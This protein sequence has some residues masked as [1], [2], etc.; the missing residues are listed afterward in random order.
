MAKIKRGDKDRL[1]AA[2]LVTQ[3]ME[4]G[5]TEKRRQIIRQNLDELVLGVSPFLRLLLQKTDDKKLHTQ[6]HLNGMLFTSEIARE[7]AT[8]M[9]FEEATKLAREDLYWALNY[10]SS[11]LPFEDEKRVDFVIEL[12]LIHGAEYERLGLSEVSWQA[13]C[14]IDPVFEAV[15]IAAQE[16]GSDSLDENA[17]SLILGAEVILEQ[18][19]LRSKLNRISRIVGQLTIAQNE[20]DRLRKQAR[21]WCLAHWTQLPAANRSDGLK[22]QSALPFK[23][24]KVARH[25][26]STLRCPECLENGNTEVSLINELISND[27]GGLYLNFLIRCKNCSL[28]TIV[29]NRCPSSMLLGFSPGDSKRFLINKLLNVQ[30]YFNYL[31]SYSLIPLAADEKISAQCKSIFSSIQEAIPDLIDPEQIKNTNIDIAVIAGMFGPK[32]SPF[33]H[34]CSDGFAIV[35]PEFF[36][37][38]LFRFARLLLLSWGIQNGKQRLRGPAISTEYAKEL[39]K[40]L[41]SE[42]GGFE[43]KTIPLKVP[44]DMT[45]ADLAILE[46]CLTFVIGHEVA[47]ICHKHLDHSASLGV[48]PL[49][50][51][52]YDS[53]QDEIAADKTA[54]RLARVVAERNYTN[55]LVQTFAMASIDIFFTVLTLVESKFPPD[56]Q[57]HPLAHVRRA[58]L[59]SYAG[60]GITSQ[61][62]LF[63]IGAQQ[64]LEA[65]AE[66]QPHKPDLPTTLCGDW[67]KLE[68]AL[69]SLSRGEEKECLKRLIPYLICQPTNDEGWQLLPHILFSESENKGVVSPRSAI[70]VSPELTDGTL[71]INLVQRL[72]KREME[73]NLWVGYVKDLAY[74]AEKK[75]GFQALSLDDELRA[76]RNVLLR[77]KHKPEPDRGTSPALI[78]LDILEKGL[79]REFTY[80]ARFTSFDRPGFAQ[81]RELLLNDPSPVKELLMSLVV[82]RSQDDSEAT[83]LTE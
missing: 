21:E 12:V 32:I 75:G 4:L 31:R 11:L 50:A 72:T 24:F 61:A 63:A 62:L 22:K 45:G 27:E 15:E 69:E 17:M 28:E 8:A 68:A 81:F 3:L 29:W 53:L 35:V 66:N 34:K 23:S 5:G 25:V 47:H 1:R 26:A 76:L 40:T 48:S 74:R 80:F 43:M 59:R 58:V 10:F 52:V 36:I 7:L 71:T 13:Y 49:G 30:E 42:F 67:Q 55:P 78:L 18:V 57:K 77:L 54:S 51:Q 83:D 33:C 82:S 73:M 79:L 64:A 20:S 65:N 70:P 38:R 9:R 39:Y 19:G 60:A 14:L 44:R 2:P 46:S 37:I 56:P 16:L 41:C 6:I